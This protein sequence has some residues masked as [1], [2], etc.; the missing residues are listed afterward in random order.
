MIDQQRFNV[1]LDGGENRNSV[2]TD[3]IDRVPVGFRHMGAADQQPE[4]QRRI[5]GEPPIQPAQQ[6]IVRPDAGDT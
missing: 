3:Q 5:G 4:I 2:L 1:V 6:V